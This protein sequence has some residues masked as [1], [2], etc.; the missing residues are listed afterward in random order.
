M[1]QRLVCLPGNQPLMDGKR[2]EPKELNWG[3]GT[4][5]E[6]CLGAVTFTNKD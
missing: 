3:E 1:A 5:D 6:M 2:I 4:H